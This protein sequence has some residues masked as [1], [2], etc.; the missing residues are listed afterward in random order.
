MKQIAQ[1]AEAIILENKNT[2]TK[3]R[4]P[5]SYRIPILDIK[6]RKSRTRKEA[7]L[8]EKAI[9]F[10]PVPKV[11]H[12]SEFELKLENI[13]GKKLAQYLEKLPSQIY[14]QIGKNLAILHNHD[15]IHGD[16]TTSNMIYS[17]KENKTFFIDFG[18]GFESPK[19]EDKAVDLHVL[20]E[21]LQAKHCKIAESAWHSIFQAYKNNSKNPAQIVSR[22]E[23]VEKRGRYKQAD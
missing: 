19:A 22:L 10:I 2:I 14:Q 13:K 20:K 12:Q 21:A 5:K 7:R 1:G 4:I 11:L 6:L 17:P 8:L 9:Q 23:A 16:L 3:N 15:I 18:L